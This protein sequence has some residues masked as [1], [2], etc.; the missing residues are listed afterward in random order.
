MLMSVTHNEHQCTRTPIQVS[1]ANSSTP[2]TGKGIDS[3]H[4]A[5]D[6][7][8]NVTFNHMAAASHHSS[9]QRETP[10]SATRE[11]ILYLLKNIQY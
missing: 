1:G 10:F 9:L 3:S 4:V 5:S 6:E 11:V 7:T 2:A 8:T